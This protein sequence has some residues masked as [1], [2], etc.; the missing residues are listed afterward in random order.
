MRDQTPARVCQRCGSW[1][2]R[3]NAG[4]SEPA[5]PLSHLHPI[6]EPCVCGGP[7]IRAETSIESDIV[8][9]INRHQIEPLH[10][11]WRE[12]VGIVSAP[13]ERDVVF[14]RELERELISG[15]A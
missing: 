6:S 1:P 4:I 13:V 9:A 5:R 10:L 3:C 15:R 2:C 14:A 12:I 8:A 7:D 11:A